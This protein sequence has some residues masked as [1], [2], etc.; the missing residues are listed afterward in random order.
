LRREAETLHA[1][2]KQRLLDY[3]AAFY[4]TYRPPYDRTLIVYER[5]PACSILESQGAS[6]LFGESE[7]IRAQKLREYQ[8]EMR[9]FS[10]FLTRSFF[11]PD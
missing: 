10:A 6:A 3:L 8:E 11:E 9:A 5:T 2:E 7:M 4:T 1:R